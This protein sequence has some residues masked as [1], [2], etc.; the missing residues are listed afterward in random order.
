MPVELHV[1]EEAAGSFLNSSPANM[2]AELDSLRIFDEPV[3]AVASADDALFQ[4]LKEEDI[5]G[6]H[7]LT[8]GE[9][10]PGARSVISL[11]LPFS[12][13]VRKSNYH[14]GDPSTEWLYARIE[15]QDCITALTSHLRQMLVEKGAK[16]V[17][18]A[19][20]PRFKV[21]NRRSNWSERHVA[22]I[23]GLGTFGLS[24]S[25]IT[26]RGS[27]GRY[28][29]LIVD[30]KLEPTIRPYRE[31][32]EYCSR[33]GACIGRC[34]ANAISLQGKDHGPCSVFLDDAKVR[35]KPRYG[36]GKCQTGVP[37]ETGIPN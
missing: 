14:S 30:F 15:G 1:L 8:P 29:S 24:K 19:L 23:A 37:C 27:A 34:P 32:Y 9:W 28:A 22:Y 20:D 16:A 31:I 17:V 7:H 4:R 33:C 35:F 5:I 13:R 2:V 21:I 11:F 12:E 25:L 36:C 6:L 26:A 10:L 3:W 18:P